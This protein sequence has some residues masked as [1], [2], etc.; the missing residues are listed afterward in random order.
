M[1]C[2]VSEPK[3]DNNSVYFSLKILNVE[4]DLYEC[5]GRRISN[6]SGPVVD[7]D[8]VNLAFLGSYSVNFL[9]LH[10][11]ARNQHIIELSTH[12]DELI[13]NEIGKVRCGTILKVDGI[14]VSNS[15]WVLYFLLRFPNFYY[16]LLTLER[17]HC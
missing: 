6:L 11:S 16:E 9:G 13:Q 4:N 7:S 1:T 5:G 17:T 14:G 15:E 3:F 12:V 10:P 8:A 2:K